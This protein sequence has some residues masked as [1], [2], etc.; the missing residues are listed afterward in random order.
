MH[1]LNREPLKTNTMGFF[2]TQWDLH[3][4]ETKEDK[5]TLPFSTY[6]LKNLPKILTFSLVLILSLILK[7]VMTRSRRR[8]L[9]KE[10]SSFKGKTFDQ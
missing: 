4:K 7:M 9:L 6:S 8:K 1:L 5:N 2:K 3:I 10:S